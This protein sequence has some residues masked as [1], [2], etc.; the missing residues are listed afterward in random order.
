MQIALIS[1]TRAEIAPFLKEFKISSPER[2]IENVIFQNH[3]VDVIITGVG[4]VATAYR[5]G[6][7][8]GK[9]HYD[10]AINA[11]IAGSYNRGIP[12][13]SLVNVHQETFSEIGAES[14]NDFLLP[15]TIGLNEFNRLPFNEGVLQNRT[16]FDSPLLLNLPKVKGLT[17]NTIH[18]NEE[19]IAMLQRLFD[20]DVET[21]EGAAF[22]YACM[23][24]NM[25]CIELRSISNYVESRD[26][27]KWEISKAI[28][29]LNQFLISYFNE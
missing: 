3:I 28:E 25:A 12:I 24:E 10:L 29:T 23:L 27:A 21:M 17:A 6:Q 20:A 11:G 22:M 2:R 16:E 7:V 5:L 1:A 19:H 26:T 9:M 18:G 8:F 15:H 13:G 4:M 14:N